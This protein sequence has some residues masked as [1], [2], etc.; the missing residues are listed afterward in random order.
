MRVETIPLVR[1]RLPDH[2]KKPP[3]AGAPRRLFLTRFGFEALRRR[4][5]LRIQRLR[6]TGKIRVERHESGGALEKR[7]ATCVIRQ[8]IQRALSI[9]RGQHATAR[10]TDRRRVE[11]V[12]R[13]LMLIRA[14]DCSLKV[15]R[16]ARSHRIKTA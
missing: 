6:E 1:E 10:Q 12:N 2:G 15:K 4:H 13:Y 3:R 8:P 5:W 11:R 16:L 9:T 14:L 7:F